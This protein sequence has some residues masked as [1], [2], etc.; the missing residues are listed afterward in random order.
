MVGLVD[1]ASEVDSAVIELA[2]PPQPVHYGKSAAQAPSRDGEH[3]IPSLV[4][5][6]D[7]GLAATNGPCQLQGTVWIEFGTDRHRCDRQPAIRGEPLF[8]RALGMADDG[9]L[10][11]P[12]C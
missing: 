2:Q 11:S 5:E 12:I 10:V 3:Y 1:L 8:D 7:V 4:G 9:Q 6:H